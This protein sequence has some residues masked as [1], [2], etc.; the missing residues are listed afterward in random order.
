MR[1]G[2]ARSARL[3]AALTGLV[4]SDLPYL[5]GYVLLTLAMTAPLIARLGTHLVGFGDDAWMHYWNNW[6]VQR[7]LTEGG[8]V[9]TTNLLFYPQSVSLVTHNFGW[10][11]VALWLVVE[12]AVGGIAAY[13]L[14]HL[15]NITLCACAMFL[16]ARHLL[17]SRGPAFVAGL[18]YGFWPYRLSDS[19]HPNMVAQQW[20]PLALLSVILLLRREG[21]VR[22]ALAAGVLLALTGLS[23]WQMLLPAGIAVGLVLLFTLLERERWPRQAIGRLALA[24][25]V[26]AVL[27]AI[28]LYPLLREAITAESYPS[29]LLDQ[30]ATAQTDLLAYLVPSLRHPLAPLFGKL[31]YARSPVRLPYSPFLGYAVL[32]LVV[33]A[34]VWRWHAVGPW[35]ALALVAFLLSLGPVLRLNDQLYPAVPMPYRLV[36]WLAPFRWMRAPHRFNAL[37]AV[38][39]AV[40]AGYGAAALRDRLARRRPTALLAV[41]SALVLFDYLNLP[42]MTVPARVPSFYLT[43]AQEPGEFAIVGLPGDRQ[44]TEPYM[45]YQTVHGRPLLV[46]H[47]SRLP[48]NA[49][50]F[51]SSVPLLDGVYETGTIDT[52]LPDLSR[53]LSP[54]SDA[55]F[56]YIILHKSLAS[57]AELAEW[58]SYLLV[59]PRYEDDE[60]AVYSTAPVVGEDCTLLYELGDGIGLIDASVSPQTVGPDVALALQVIWGT[61]A[62]PGADLQLEVALVDA[63]GEAQQVERFDIS[64]GWPTA[65]WPANTIVRERYSFLVEPWLGDGP[66][67]VTVR[68]VRAQDGRPIGPETPVGEVSVQAPERSFAV[69]PMTRTTNVSFGSALRL[70]GYD[71]DVSADRLRLTLHWQALQRMDRGYKFFVHLYG[72]ESEAPVVQADTMPHDW[73][74]PTTWWEVGE[75]VSDEIP[76]ALSGLP[77]GSYRLAVGV[78]DP[79]TGTRLAVADVTAGMESSDDRLLLPEMIARNDEAGP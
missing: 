61:A 35:A 67:S 78:Y 15:A 23:R 56:R 17:E 70:L 43:L 1:G 9:Y 52:D 33:L 48:A 30:E 5:L 63:T 20:L 51:V 34:V 59:A 18:V 16:L 60:V 79:E 27:V 66:H 13:N 24:A 58:R 7:V 41:L 68:L 53:Q 39:V 12:P 10:T 49:L 4:R 19:V 29:L 32:G 6:W 11:N 8:S 47:I 37:L 72:E 40:L 54:L 22:H 26:A 62:P 74:Y 31:A 65:D 2:A 57:P 14:V 25:L 73:T 21:R 71:L 55:G 45:Y 64:P 69:P 3:R 76:L 38:P 44:S 36:G 28:P 77:G 46:G 75:V 42:M 50:A